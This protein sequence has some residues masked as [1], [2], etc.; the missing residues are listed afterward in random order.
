M[1]YFLKNT[2]IACMSNQKYCSIDFG[3]HDNVNVIINIVNNKDHMNKMHKI[4]ILKTINNVDTCIIF[5]L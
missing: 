3:K 2:N 5:I 4:Y 1:F